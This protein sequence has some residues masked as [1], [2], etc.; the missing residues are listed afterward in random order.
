MTRNQ[1]LEPH[2]N[3][4]NHGQ[5]QKQQERAIREAYRKERKIE[6]YLADDEN[7]P[8]FAIQLKKLGL[9]LRDIPA[10]G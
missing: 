10:D 5:L 8:S 1:R 9:C 6:S 4:N 3:N 2:A 7:F